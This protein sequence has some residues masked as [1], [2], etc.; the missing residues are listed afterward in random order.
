MRSTARTHWR[1]RYGDEFDD[2]NTTAAGDAG[3]IVTALRDAA[4]QLDE[5][6]RLAQAEQERRVQARAW[7]EQNDNGGGIGGFIRDVGDGISDFFTGDEDVPPP[8]PPIEPPS[9]PVEDPGVVTRNTAAPAAPPSYGTGGV[10]QARPDDLDAW[11]SSSRGLDELVTPKKTS[12]TNLH[13]DFTGSLGYGHFDASSVISAVG[14]W[15]SL[16]ETD[17]QWVTTIAQA[18]RD[19]G[20]GTVSDAVIHDRLAAAH[21]DG[22]RGSITFDDPVAWG[23]PPTSGY[24]DDPVNTASGNFVEAEVDVVATG[25]TRLLRFTRTCNSRSDRPGPFGPGWASWASVR[26]RAE[27]DGARWTGPDGQEAVFPRAPDGTYRRIPGVPGVPVVAADGN[28]ADGPSPTFTSNGGPGLVLEGVGGHSRIVF[29]AAGRPV[30]ADD[31]PGTE[32]TFHHDGDRLVA[33]RHPGRSLTLEWDGDR[34]VALA[35]D[36]GRRVEYRY[37]D[38]G[39]LVEA[40]GGPRG[41]RRYEIGA[42]GRV[43]AVIDADGVVEVR[44]TYDEEGRVVEQRSPFGRRTRYRYLGGRVTVVSDDEGGPTGSYVHDDHGRLVGAIDGHGNELTKAYDRWGNP[45]RVTERD[46]STTLLTW[47]DHGRLVRRQAPDG[48]WFT[49]AHDDRGRVVQV[50]ASTGATT[51]Y[52]YRG[53]E[54]TP[55]EVVD[56]EGGVTRLQV[57]GGLVRRVTDSDGVEVR[58]GYDDRGELTSITDG[59]GN[60]ATIERD[61]AG[62]VTAT[63]AASG[64]RTELAYDDAGRLVRRRDPDGAEWRWEWSAAGR[65]VATVD[66]L[67]HRHERRYGSHGEAEELV[68]PLGHTTTH[69]YD[70]LGRLVGIVL[71]DG[72]KWELDHDGLG[73]LTAVADPAGGAWLREYDAVGRLIGTIDPTGGRRTATYDAAGRLARVHDG[74]VGVELGYDPLGRPTD[75]RPADAVGSAAASGATRTEYDRCGRVVAVTDAT[76]ATTRYELTPGG[77]VAAVISPLGHVTRYEHDRAGRV[78]AVVDPTGGRWTR[79]LDAEGRVTQIV[80]PTGEITRLRYDAAGRLA[81]R[82]AST[83]GTT[84]YEHDLAGR[85]VAVTDPVGGT[86]RYTWD[87]RGQLVAATDP[88]GGVTRYERDERGLLRTIVDPLGGRVEHR[89]DPVGRLVEQ[90]DQLG[91]STHWRYDAAGRLVERVLPTGDRVRWRYDGAGRLRSIGAGVGGSGVGGSGGVGSGG[92][93]EDD[94]VRIERDG[95][96]RPVVVEEPGYRHELE[97]DA[98]GRLVARRRNGLG[99]AWTYDADGRCTSVVHPDGAAITYEHDA[100]GRVVAATHPAVG[101]ITQ[102]HDDAGRLVARVS[103]H[104]AERWAWRDGVLVGHEVEIDGVGQAGGTGHAIVTELE[105]DAAGRVVAATV[106]GARTS[107]AY[108]PAG[109]LVA[110]DGPGGAW[111]FEHDVAGRLVVEE[112]PRGEVRYAYDE[113]HQLVER[114]VDGARTRYAHDAAGRRVGVTR[115]DGSAVPYEWDWQ[116]HLAAVGDL[117]LRVDALGDLA[118]ADGMPMVWDPAGVV[119]RLRW[120]D[121]HTLVGVDDAVCAV[122]SP[123]L[124]AG[125][126]GAASG[127]AAGV[128]AAAEVEW[129]PH[130]WQGSVVGPAGPPAAADPWGAAADPTG[131]RLG[132]RGEL[133]LDGLVWLRNRAYDPATRGF[134]A[135]DPLGGVPGLPYAAHPYHYGGNDPIGQVDPLG[136]RPMTEADL[137][138]YREAAADSGLFD[139]V[140]DAWDATTGWVADNWEYIAAGALIVGGVVVMATGFGGPIGAAMIGGALMSGGISAGSQRLLTGEVNWGQ[141]GVDMLIGGAAGGAGAW[142]SSAR[143]AATW[144]TAGR[145]AFQVGVNTTADVA[146]GMVSRGVQ[147]QNPL[148]LQAMGI[149]ALTG[150][151]VGSADVAVNVFRNAHLTPTTPA[152][153][154]TPPTRPTFVVE[155]DG[156]VRPMPPPG[157]VITYETVAPRPVKPQDAVDRWDEFLGEGPHTNIHPRTGLP[158]PDRIV[159]ADG[160]RSIRYGDHEMNSRPTRHHYHEETWMHDST[161]DAWWVDNTVVRVPLQ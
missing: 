58:F 120:I 12:L 78:V 146:G 55:V 89:Y 144:S 63:V 68:D 37:D 6:A 24:S 36:D 94:V 20:T 31:G 143:F 70:Q 152:V 130:D 71:P 74:A 97:W 14:T 11:A 132:Y 145:G 131:V 52:V 18:F 140:A 64:R 9:I 121:G 67:G 50:T 104:G 129:Q 60:T 114:S 42:D 61:A 51:S 65:P 122:V 151:A 157:G 15:V 117:S 45:V 153:D 95:Q 156:T 57:E 142:A 1:G 46:G 158:D 47:D 86:T 33:L 19:A 161:N 3:R 21:L 101:R 41:R 62:R 32:V 17:A 27:P 4:D 83:G 159:S 115:P 34:I 7:V 98:A 139:H 119:P 127:A 85:L 53:D 56:A 123:R 113:A 93:G 8:G 16:N 75:A 110:V 106:D 135:P 155:P 66:P 105:R 82:V 87:A 96:G 43:A 88:N 49:F 72:A 69:R 138:A 84:R 148:D 5:L 13:G 112:A 137:A 134:L 48:S 150:T 118:E 111:R 124:D 154:P 160:T 90:R 125:A 26:L 40:T 99:L 10:S 103:D 2:R 44:N 141:V 77:R 147:G 126:G 81:A 54:R 108:D 100:A 133:E 79:R 28:A 29:D 76:G 39:R 38:D 116:G 102:A 149:D 80:A 23:E 73:R 25:L 30:R 136:L 22:P 91:R 35:T 92:V 109:Q 128:G 107:Y 59:L